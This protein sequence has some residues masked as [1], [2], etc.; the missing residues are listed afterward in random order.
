[1]KSTR[2][3]ER[4]SRRSPATRSRRWSEGSIARDAT[5]IFGGIGF[6]NDTPVARF[7]RDAKIL[8]VGKGISEV[9]CMFIA[10]ELGL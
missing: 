2:R 10:R 5:Q 7:Y 6:I 3:C 1:V 8:E 4:P 9:Q